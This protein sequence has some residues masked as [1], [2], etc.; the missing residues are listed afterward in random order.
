MPSYADSRDDETMPERVSSLVLFG[1]YLLYLAFASY[2]LYRSRNEARI[3]RVIKGMIVAF[4][5]GEA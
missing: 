3:F 4:L 1:V 5:V 2:K